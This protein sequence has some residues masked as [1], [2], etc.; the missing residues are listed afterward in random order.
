MGEMK[1]KIFKKI[2]HTLSWFCYLFIIVYALLCAPYIFGYKPLVVLTGSMEPTFK[3]GSIIYYKTVSKNEIKEGDIIT[4]KSGDSL[5]SHRV[6]KIENYIYETKG[7]A[8]NT[9]DAN[10]I[11]FSDIVGKDTNINIPYVGYYVKYINDHMY[12]LIIVAVVLVLDFILSNIKINNEKSIEK[13][14]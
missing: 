5:V 12:I 14:L 8:N 3:T 1:M 10:R 9:V 11:E 7:D 2:V 13:N 6:N 4:F